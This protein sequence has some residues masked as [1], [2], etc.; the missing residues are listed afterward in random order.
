MLVLNL[1]GDVPERTLSYLAKDL[2]EKIET[3]KG[4]LEA[5]LVGDR[6]E[7]MEIII[8]PL[9]MESYQLNPFEILTLVSANNK[10]VSAGAMQDFA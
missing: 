2:K 1:A 5:V 10:L 3:N 9:A 4:V 7:V 6:E 8:D